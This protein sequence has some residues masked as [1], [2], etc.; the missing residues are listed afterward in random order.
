MKQKKKKKEMKALKY[1]AVPVLSDRC[2]NV[3]TVRWLGR[4][5][6]HSLRQLS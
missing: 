6:Q 5:Q 3:T 2:E 4:L 1:Y